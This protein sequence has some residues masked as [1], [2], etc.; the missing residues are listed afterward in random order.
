M[1]VLYFL[2]RSSSAD[3]DHQNDR[4][5]REI[6]SKG[7]LLQGE[8]MYYF[9]EYLKKE[10]PAYMPVIRM[11]EGINLCPEFFTDEF[12]AA[13]RIIADDGFISHKYVPAFE[14]FV[15]HPLLEKL[16]SYCGMDPQGGRKVASEMT[17][18]L[19]PVKSDDVLFPTAQ[20]G[21]IMVSVAESMPENQ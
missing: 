6:H 19:E 2:S 13:L 1:A 12:K 8:H 18:L 4:Q 7:Y 16:N 9:Q 20:I 11:T 21:M 10:K 3:M 17:A 5:I 15:L 14:A